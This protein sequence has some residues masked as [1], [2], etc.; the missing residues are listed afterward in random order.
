MNLRKKTTLI[1]P[2]PVL[3]GLALTLSSA[4]ANVA[5]GQAQ[6]QPSPSPQPADVTRPARRPI[7][8]PQYI[9]AHDYDQRNIKL[10]LRFDWEREQAFGTAAITLAPLVRDLRRVDLDAAVMTISNVALPSGT[11]LKY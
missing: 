2:W 8:P 9:P 11:E 7:P 1:F 10:D 4:A 5:F 6:S 3:I